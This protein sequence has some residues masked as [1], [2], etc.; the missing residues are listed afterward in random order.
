MKGGYLSRD[1]L[2]QAIDGIWTHFLDRL[3]WD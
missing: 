2:G 3:G 1:M